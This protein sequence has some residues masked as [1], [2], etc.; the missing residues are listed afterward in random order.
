[1]TYPYETDDKKRCFVHLIHSDKSESRCILH[2]DHQDNDSDHIDEH[3]HTAKVLVT[4]ATI[5]EVR[6]LAEYDRKKREEEETHEREIDE[7]VEEIMDI[8]Y[9]IDRLRAVHRIRAVIERIF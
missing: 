5:R 9:G 4:Q 6:A 2:K 1:M 7:I 8:A 3:G